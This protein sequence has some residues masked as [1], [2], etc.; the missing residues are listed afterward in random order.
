MWV[1]EN[2]TIACSLFFVLIYQI[3]IILSN[4]LI[5]YL[6]SFMLLCGL[7]NKKGHCRMEN[8]CQYLCPVALQSARHSRSLRHNHR[9][10]H[11]SLGKKESLLDYFCFF[12]FF[13]N[14][15]QA[16]QKFNYNQKEI[17]RYYFNNF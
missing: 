3:K 15:S 17:F 6:S 14:L 2:P 12:V 13:C 5:L 11:H 9:H 7:C 16:L 1:Q 10:S 4:H 8:L